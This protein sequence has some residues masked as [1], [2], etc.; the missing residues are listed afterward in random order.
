MDR[1][2]YDSDV[3]NFAY[4]VFYTNGKTF[5][6]YVD[7]NNHK[8]VGGRIMLTPYFYLKQLRL[9]HS[10]WM[11]LIPHTCNT[12][13]EISNYYYPRIELGMEDLVVKTEFAI[14]G[15][16]NIDGSKDVDFS[17]GYVD[18]YYTVGKLHLMCD[19]NSMTQMLITQMI[20]KLKEQSV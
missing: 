6:D 17:A 2:N 14:S 12:C 16:K 13:V 10:I 5:I 1:G 8:A 11:N 9:Y 20:R 19:M 18:A 7:D 4:D 3:L 15:T